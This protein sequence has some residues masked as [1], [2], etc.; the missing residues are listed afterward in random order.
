MI[1]RSAKDQKKKL[2][3]KAETLL[4]LKEADRKS[5]V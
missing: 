4:A 3:T 5:V 2:S 1:S